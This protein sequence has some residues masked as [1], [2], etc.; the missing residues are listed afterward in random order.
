MLNLTCRKE[1]RQKK[2]WLQRSESVVHDKTM[3]NLRNRIA[4]RLTMKKKTFKLTSRFKLDI[5]TKL[6]V[7]KIFENDLVAMRKAKLHESLTKQH[8]SKCEYQ[9]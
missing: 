7:T 5:K 3:E 1:Q 8:T 6:Y 9:I 2:K 4:V